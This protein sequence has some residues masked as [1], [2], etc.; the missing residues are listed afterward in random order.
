MRDGICSVCGAKR[1]TKERADYDR[2][3]GSAASRGYG[4]N[5]QAL[6]EMI[7]SAEPLCR[8]CAKQGLVIVAT[9]VDH[10]IPKKQGG[11]DSEDN[12]QPLCHSCHSRKT[13]RETQ[14]KV[15]SSGPTVKATIITGPPGAGKTTWVKD[16]AHWGD[17]IVDM[18]ALY[19]ALSGLPWYQ[20]PDAL[21]PFVAEAR[22]AVLNRLTL[23]ADIR[24]AW[25]ITS[26]ADAS[27][28]LAMKARYNA[29][30]FILQVSANECIQRIRQDE[31]RKDTSGWAELVNGWWATYQRTK[32][33]L[34]SSAEDG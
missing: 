11:E 17:L 31:R 1:T 28:L 4:R 21:L 7:L 14:L 15:K 25:I 23:G 10:I 13:M 30:L 33:L 3:R 2:E 16:K 22:D 19:A 34:K 27:R 9:E 12:L 26:E 6:R 18:D 8:E 24:H 20:K 29:K 32:H 5:W